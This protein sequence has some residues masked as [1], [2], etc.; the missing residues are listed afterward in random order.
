MGDEAITEYKLERTGDA[1]VQFTGQLIAQGSSHSDEGPRSD[2]WHEVDIYQT[3]GGKWIGYIW[4]NGRSDEECTVIV[5][6]SQPHLRDKLLHY[7][8][9]DSKSYKRALSQALSDV[10]LFI[11]E[12]E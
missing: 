9:A 3:R 11:E 8:H 2:T 5:F 10:E 6:D 4:F 12:I 1:L 7:G